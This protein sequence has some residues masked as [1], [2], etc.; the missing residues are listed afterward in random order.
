MSIPADDAAAL[1]AAIGTDSFG[2][3]L[4]R[5]CRRFCCFEMSCAFAFHAT[6][7]PVLVHDGYSSQLSRKV[8]SRY[9]Q[10]GYLLDPFYPASIA[11]TK[12][13][14][15]RMQDLSPDQFQGSEFAGSL[16]IH[17]CIS[18]QAG[19]LV[20]EIGFLVPL[21]GG[22]SMTYSLMRDHRHACF[23]ERE[24]SSL[25][26]LTGVVAAACRQHWAGMSAR[27]KAGGDVES[28]LQRAF[29][30][31][32]TPMQFEVVTMILRGHSGASIAAALGISAGTVKVHRHNAYQRLGITTQADLF[33]LF[34]DE[35]ET[36]SESAS[37]TRQ[38]HDAAGVLTPG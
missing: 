24:F 33:A 17:P 5:I 19:A 1:L 21:D 36:S 27:S 30:E 32:L 20:E 28:V 23:D 18:A 25:D 22:W 16:A 8:L 2:K 10:G 26:S 9:L 4:D 37:T 34:I 6:R 29:G 14:L 15:W 7:L 3:G 35:L 13:G 11:S 12:A 38:A 31:A